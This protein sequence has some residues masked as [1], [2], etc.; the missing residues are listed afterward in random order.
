MKGCVLHASA[1]SYCRVG[2][3]GVKERK[4]EREWE[5]DREGQGWWWRL[6][7]SKTEEV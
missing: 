6:E 7:D 1:D 2:E 3:G 4:N 5:G